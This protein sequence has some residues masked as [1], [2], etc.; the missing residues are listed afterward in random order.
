VRGD[1]VGLGLSIAKWIVEAHHGQITVDSEVGVGTT[2][3]VTIPHL[4]DRI[5]VTSE[6]VTRPRLRLLRRG[7]PSSPQKTKL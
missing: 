1:G 7:S 5:S 2:F 6:Q 3:R 4:E